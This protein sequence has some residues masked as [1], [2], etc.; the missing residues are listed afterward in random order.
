MT[1]HVQHRVL[2][3]VRMDGQAKTVEEVTIHSV[4]EECLS[5]PITYY[6]ICVIYIVKKRLTFSEPSQLKDTTFNAKVAKSRNL[7][8]DGK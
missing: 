6:E 2:A 8:F 4:A 3:N 5:A 1:A 7:K